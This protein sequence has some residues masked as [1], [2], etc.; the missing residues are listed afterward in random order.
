MID[1]MVALKTK[2]PAWVKAERQKQLQEGCSLKV[3][4][5]VGAK[6]SHQWRKY[7]I[8]NLQQAILLVGAAHFLRQVKIL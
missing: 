2:V 3:L 6:S 7:K 1:L 8:G 4:Q 5:L